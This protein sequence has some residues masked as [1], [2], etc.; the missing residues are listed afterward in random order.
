MKLQVGA[1]KSSQSRDCRIV[2]LDGSD[3][4]VTVVTEEDDGAEVRVS[5]SQMELRDLFT[6]VKNKVD[7]DLIQPL[8][9]SRRQ[10][11]WRSLLERLARNFWPPYPPQ[12]V[13]LDQAEHWYRQCLA[14]RKAGDEDQAEAARKEALRWVRSAE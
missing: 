12:E 6:G 8:L 3:V 10:I 9:L 2:A 4:G 5:F 1:L 7:P 11:R 13:R 14:A